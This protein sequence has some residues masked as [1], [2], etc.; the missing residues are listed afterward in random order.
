MAEGAQDP[1]AKQTVAR[2]MALSYGYNQSSF[3]G[4]ETLRQDRVLSPEEAEFDDADRALEDL[5]IASRPGSDHVQAIADGEDFV[6]FERKVGTWTHRFRSRFKQSA[7]GG[8]MDVEQFTELVAPEPFLQNLLTFPLNKDLGEAGCLF[9]SALVLCNMLADSSNPLNSYMA[10]TE[11]KIVEVG[12]GTGV[13]GIAA[14]MLGCKITVT[15]LPHVMPQIEENV[16][17]NLGAEPHLFQRV[18][19]APLAWGNSEHSLA[20][21]K[22]DLVLCSDCLY[23]EETHTVLLQTLK[24]CEGAIRLG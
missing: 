24:V 17:K 1:G 3:P 23:R 14:A 12:S 7:E 10:D 21:G 16:E 6:I 8:K 15:D 5:C 13:V 18:T 2:Y 19:C 9:Q 4:K 11:R 20:L 22:A